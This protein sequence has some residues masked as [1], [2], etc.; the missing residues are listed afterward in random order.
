MSDLPGSRGREV[1]SR[2]IFAAIVLPAGRIGDDGIGDDIG[3][4]GGAVVGGVG[5]S[6]VA[7]CNNWKAS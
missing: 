7:L 6:N 3:G 5:G 2:L 4:V 1:S